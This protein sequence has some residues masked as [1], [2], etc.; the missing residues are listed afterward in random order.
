L[1]NTISSKYNGRDALVFNSGYHANIGILPSIAGKGDLI[2]S[3]K[4]NHASIIDGILLSKAD[5]IR[6]KHLDYENLISILEKKRSQYNDIF[7]V[8]ESVF[9]MDGDIVDLNK[10]IEIKKKF[11]AY[12]YIDEAHAVGVFGANGLGICEEQNAINDI[13]LIMGTFGKALAS[14]GAFCITHKY[15][16]DYLINKMRS[17]IFTTALPPVVIN[18][19][20]YIFEKLKSFE[21]KRVYLKDLAKKF[22]DEIAKYKLETKG[23]THIMPII[24]KDNK[25]TLAIADELQK[26]GY[27]IFA[28]RPPT[29]PI[30][31]ARLRIS[32]SS[33]MEW[34]D[35]K[36]IPKIIKNL[37][38]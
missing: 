1:E 34:E 35:I 2:L 37:N 14:V 4:L 10:L 29:V 31:Q 17:F 19:N 26:E 5:F 32:L 12:V 38:I 36:N 11:N 7:I 28:I 33:D 9:S 22:R 6:Y 23:S 8:S 21:S 20:N 3:D 25:K 16:K 15:L 18:W 13:D 30:N 27:L 24:I